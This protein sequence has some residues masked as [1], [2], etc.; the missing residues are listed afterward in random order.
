MNILNL[1]P[2]TVVN[3]VIPK[4]AFEAKLTSAQ[5]RKLTDS[6]E[7]IRWANKLSAETIN[8][9]GI[10]IHEIQIFDIQLKKS[11]DVDDLLEAIQKIIPYPIIFFVTIGARAY[12]STSQKHAHPAKENTSVIDWTFKSALQGKDELKYQLDLK[13]N[14][15]YVFRTFCLQLSSNV[16]TADSISELV[17]NEKVITALNAKIAKLKAAINR[18]SQF[19]KRVELNI[20]LHEIERQLELLKNE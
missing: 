8:L 15:D 9:T 10:E 16:N 20:E 2:Q 12:F 5:K 19:N 11:E 13:K 1:P 6:I 18:E 7:R 4:N 14:L 3:K 17:E